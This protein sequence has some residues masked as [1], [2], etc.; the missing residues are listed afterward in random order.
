MDLDGLNCYPSKATLAK[1]MGCSERTVARMLNELKAAG[2]LAWRQRPQRGTARMNSNIYI[3]MIPDGM[4]VDSR[5][6][7][8][9]SAEMS[10]D[11]TGEVLSQS[12]TYSDISE[13]AALVI[14][15]TC[16]FL[17]DQHQ[18]DA[19]NTDGYLK[20]VD[21][22]QATYLRHGKEGLL[23]L[24]EIIL[25]QSPESLEN[26]ISPLRV[27]AYRINAINMEMPVIDPTL[28]YS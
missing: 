25:Q 9:L 18:L 1:R 12:S 24:C 19:S 2:W 3:P 13:D 4:E 11:R 17:R 26:A 6:M 27:P 20:Y 15:A 10:E 21:A 8:N 5:T 28:P 23:R 22:V 7:D 16:V 14:D